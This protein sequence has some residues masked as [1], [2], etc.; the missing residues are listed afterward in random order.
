MQ[1][2][3]VNLTDE[4]SEEV[5]SQFV[6]PENPLNWRDHIIISG[7]HQLGFSII[8]QLRAAGIRMV[9]VDDDPD[10]RLARQ[11]QRLKIKMIQDDARIPETLVEA[12]I[13]GASA[14]MACEENDLHNFE[15]VLVANDL[16]PGIRA[17]AS[18]FSQK[19]G[20]QL[21]KAVTNAKALSL[22][23]KAAPSFVEACTQ[24]SILHLFTIKERDVAIV[25][26]RV[27][28]AGTIEQLFGA[29]P[30]LVV[31]DA[32]PSPIHSSGNN[33][34]SA[35]PTSKARWEICPPRDY[36]VHPGQAVI[37]AGQVEELKKLPGVKLDK[38]DLLGAIT[39]LK[40]VQTEQE[41]GLQKKLHN[42]K[43]GRFHRIT[44]TRKVIS[45][46]LRDMELPFRYALLF[47]TL[48]MCISTLMLRF[49]YHNTYISP[50]GTS[51]EFT[52]LD[53][54]YFTVTIMTTAGFGDYNFAHQEWG[55]KLFGVFLTLVGAA[56]VSV[57]YAFVTNAIIN[58]RI[59]Q[60][61]G[62]NKATN[63][64]NHI[65]MCGLGSVGYQVMQGLLKQ[66]EEIAVIEKNEQGRF[67]SEARNQGI[68]I[69]YG[70]AK[71]PQVLK[72]V[73]IHKAKAIAILNSDDLANL[74]TALSAYTEFHIHE[75]NHHKN[76]QVVLR[77]FDNKLAERVAKNFDINT[78]YSA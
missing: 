49:F 51:M 16:V 45:N 20:E 71:L 14:I 23:E 22:S 70:D 72:A 21:T 58:R 41:E 55:L 37:L 8:E 53:A 18:F 50:Q 27:A 64:E 39:S 60:T 61:L 4:L 54:L 7:L 34:T 35:R 31:R 62:R 66:G 47:V 9:V 52:L 1:K 75:N 33:Y 68:P 30:P 28:E 56:S 29:N 57:V 74:E 6:D 10:P 67:N 38:T 65:V 25:E 11:V 26:A 5:E 19:V 36:R 63:M 44:Q 43:L 24:S 12:G 40:A 76:L 3:T 42:K 48:V 77:V 69:I 59:E 78:S 32:E 13:Y 17:V 73:N 15:T 46:L 2:F